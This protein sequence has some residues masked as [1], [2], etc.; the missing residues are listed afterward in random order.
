[1]AA[2][3]SNPLKRALRLDKLT[4]AALLEVLKLY[5]DPATLS[6]KLA[7]LALTDPPPWLI[8][9]AQAR[10]LL[11]SLESILPPPYQVHVAAC[12]SQIGSGSLPLETLPSAALCLHGRENDDAGLRHLAAGLA[13]RSPGR[14]SAD[15][16]AAPC[17]WTCAAWNRTRN[18]PSWTNWTRCNCDR[19][20]GRARGPRQKPLWYNS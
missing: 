15:F 19:R 3:E 8:S 10:R 11:P 17:G 5:R 16:I 6:L 18:R 7:G 4:L 9:E 12:S 1:M 20:H 14:S 13:P 2:I